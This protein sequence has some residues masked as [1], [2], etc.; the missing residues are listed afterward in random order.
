MAPGN[1]AYNM[2][3]GY[4]LRGSLD[5]EALEKSFNE[6][7]RRH[8]TL[9]TS[10]AVEDGEPVQII[11]PEF[12]ISIKVTALDHLSASQAEHTSHSLAS[13]LSAQPFDLR[14]LPLL[15]VFLFKLSE[16]EH[17]LIINFHHI[18]AD[19]LST[20]LLL[21]E[22][23]TFYSAFTEGTA[24]RPP[25]LTIQYGDFALWQQQTMADETNYASH[26]EFWRKQLGG[27]VPDLELPADKRRPA[28][29]SFNGSNVFFDIPDSLV[30]KVKTL[31]AQEGCTPFMSFLAVFQV[32]LHRYSG[33]YDIVIGTPIAA[34]TP[35]QLVPLIGL[36]LN[37]TALRCDLSGNPTF[38]GLLR[39]TRDT[40]LKTFSN[41]KVP[42]ELLMKHLK[43]QRDPSRNPVF[44]VAF[45]MSSAA[46]HRIGVLQVSSFDLN[47]KFGPFDLT[48]HLRQT[49]DG[50]RAR[51]EYCS[52][53]FET[54]TAERL[55][56][57]YQTLL[58]TSVENAEQS[59]STLPMLTQAEQHHALHG[60]NKTIAY[61]KGPCLHEHFQKQV[62]LTPDAIAVV[63]EDRRLTYSELNRRSNQLAHHLRALGVTADQLVGLRTERNIEMVVGILGILKAGGAYLPLDPV[64]PK[65]RVAFMLEDSGVTLIVTQRS[66]A[67]D[68]EDLAV[69][70]VLL[71]E[72]PAGVDTNPIPVSSAD[73]LAYVIYTSGSTGKPK[74][75]LITHHNVTRLFHATEAWYHFDHNDVWS[76]FHSCAFDFSVWELWGALIYGGRV[77]LVPYWTSRSPEAFREL[78]VREGVTVLNQTPSA[79]RQLMQADLAN[80][81]GD[82]V[83]RYVIF[84]GEALELQSLRPWFER[85][86]DQHP[87]LVNMYGIT[88]TTVHV[89]YRPIRIEDLEAGRGSVIGA[90]I[91]DL[92]LYILDAHGQ[93]TPIGAPGEIYVGGAGVARGY[94]NRPDLTAQRFIPDT[95]SNGQNRLYRTG[96]RARRLANGDIEYLGRIDQQVKI[97]GF[98]IEPA[99][100][101]AGIA[102]HPAVREVAVIAQEDT[103]GDQQL[104]AYIVAENA[105]HDLADQLRALLRASLPEYMVP[106]HFI[107]LR[108]LPLTPNG[109]L[110]REALSSSNLEALPLRDDGVAPRTPTEEM[111]IGVFHNVLKRNDFGVFDNFFDL[112]GHSLMAARLISGLRTASGVDLPLRELFARQTAAG[113]AEALDALRW[114]Q[115]SPKL[116]C[117]S[118]PREDIL[119]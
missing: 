41:S 35:S 104:V 106:A 60:W 3:Y 80:P 44:Q 10:I 83:L 14:Q 63:C 85:Y 11:H 68:L 12:K 71:D 111:V 94:L 93:P 8:E 6:I 75:A 30:Q 67:A 61:A 89:T 81:R 25:E 54:Q 22:L 15:R 110:D 105:P 118:N 51:F 72:L 82:L 2:P 74:G 114:M 27:P 108:A 47:P 62:E 39:K 16:D 90:P 79:F 48:L 102:R 32:L 98:R 100:I 31:S 36:I 69:S 58:E 117:G 28:I 77:V 23:D 43:F 109:K 33:G 42:L 70:S 17:I 1:P 87:V 91:P 34:R 107:M 96:D 55:C 99:E 56:K 7:V 5:L 19:G 24:P 59:I 88:E 103:S 113:L 64:Y 37:M 112:G 20:A 73:N 116:Q 21:K 4:R 26:L 18:I 49:T 66:L 76:V 46:N 9:R 65:D 101:E 53:L 78:L 97:R 50:Y 13:Q 115:Q 57:H 40:V 86:G 29:Q 95:F 119:L 45:E 92:Q 38:T 52:D 84:G